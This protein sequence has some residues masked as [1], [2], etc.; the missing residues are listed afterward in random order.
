MAKEFAETLRGYK[1]QI[2]GMARSFRYS[3]REQ[4]PNPELLT[5]TWPDEKPNSMLSLETSNLDLYKHWIYIDGEREKSHKGS[6]ANPFWR[7]F[8]QYSVAK[9][10]LEAGGMGYK[11][12]RDMLYEALAEKDIASIDHVLL[13]WLEDLKKYEGVFPEAWG[14]RRVVARKVEESMSQNHRPT[15][16]AYIRSIYLESFGDGL[17][18]E[19]KTALV[20]TS[21]KELQK[22]LP[23]PY[24]LA[25]T[26][27]RHDADISYPRKTRYE[28]HGNDMHWILTFINLADRNGFGANVKPITE[29]LNKALMVYDPSL[30]D[31]YFTGYLMH[32]SMDK[33][34]VDK[35][36]RDYF[37]K[38]VVSS[39][40]SFAPGLHGTDTLFAKLVDVNFDLGYVAS[41]L[42][43]YKSLTEVTELTSSASTFMQKE[44]EKVPDPNELYKTV[45]LPLYAKKW[46][47][48]L[49]ELQ[50]G[51]SE[52]A[53]EE[54]RF[55]MF[56]WVLTASHVEEAESLRIYRRT[57][58]LEYIKGDFFGN[59]LDLI[60]GSMT[61]AH[62]GEPILDILKTKIAEAFDLYQNGS[63]DEEYKESRA[64]DN[65]RE[66]V[67]ALITL[68]QKGL[69]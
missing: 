27:R 25:E 47:G 56:Q 32:Y 50:K 66:A 64:R 38:R 40:K 42:K 39:V 51:A 14:D 69:A 18:Q 33:R 34:F 45:Y 44:T 24:F 28:P 6:F 15:D 63:F 17:T 68:R 62:I 55:W 35:K 59:Q 43:A 23:D 30:G 21:V 31:P 46:N 7:H 10:G 37:R 53:Q 11:A 2:A 16:R 61:N 5:Q 13:F 41:A 19:E 26:Y 54:M 36:T 60:A 65:A 1:D 12:A 48:N 49:E 58:V 52:D 67:E 8:H 9:R 29:Y 57:D 22:T 3:M 20:E 4:M